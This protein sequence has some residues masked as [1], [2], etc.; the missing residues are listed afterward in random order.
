VILLDEATSALDSSTEKEIQMNIASLFRNKTTIMIA[1]RLS[2][3]RRADEIIVLDMGNIIER[4]S[5]N[6]L[7]GKNG[8]YAAM[9]SIQTDDAE[10]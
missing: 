8:R 2:T 10:E 6:E 9:W 1:H 4:G 5:H 3:A 7:L